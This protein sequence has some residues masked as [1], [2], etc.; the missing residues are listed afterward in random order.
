VG[1]AITLRQFKKEP[2]LVAHIHFIQ[3]Y[4]V[5][6]SRVH[7]EVAYSCSPSLVDSPFTTLASSVVALYMLVKSLHFEPENDR[8]SQS[9]VDSLAFLPLPSFFLV[10]GAVSSSLS[11][12]TGDAL[13]FLE[14]AFFGAGEAVP[15]TVPSILPPAFSIFLGILPVETLSVSVRTV[16][17]IWW[18]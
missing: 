11:P 4:D 1:S 6:R 13:R 7:D 2:I 3:K 17:A 15:P 9:T 8:Q 14:Q 12:S 16:L 18:S 5:H 10:T